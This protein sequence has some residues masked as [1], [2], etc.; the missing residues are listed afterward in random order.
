MN[1]V[2][3]AKAPKEPFAMADLAAMCTL[4]GVHRFESGREVELMVV[5]SMGEDLFVVN[6][7]WI[8]P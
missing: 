6:F 3:G 2:L 7:G 5:S 8:I 1:I 4:L